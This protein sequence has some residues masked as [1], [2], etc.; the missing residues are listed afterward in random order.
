MLG[1]EINRG[2]QASAV[3]LKN[4]HEKIRFGVIFLLLGSSQ[5]EKI[6][7]TK[8]KNSIEKNLT[9]ESLDKQFIKDQISEYMH[10]YDIMRKINF[11][12]AAKQE[13]D[14]EYMDL[15][16]EKRQISKELRNILNYLTPFFK[17]KNPI[18]PLAEP[19]DKDNEI[20]L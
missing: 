3:F 19:E 20:K 15:L 18:T 14:K 8:T 11:Q 13:I 17:E 10:Y 4:F 7:R 9:E 1:G 6:A 2:G 5:S 12:L 16:K